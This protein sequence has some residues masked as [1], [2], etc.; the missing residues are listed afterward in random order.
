MSESDFDPALG[1]VSSGIYI[2]TVG[3]GERSTGMLASWVMQA[4]F[5]PP[6]VSVAVKSGRYVEEWLTAGEPLVLNIVAEKQFELLKHFGSGF[7]IGEPAFEGV[8]IS[9]CPRGV[10]ILTDCLGHLE[11]EPVSHVDSGDHRIFLANV[12]RGSLHADAHSSETKP[13]IHIRKTGSHY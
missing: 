5:E 12:V 3:S 1:R 10:P 8:T 6:M 11:C 13:M 4:G 9:R 7:D 2:L